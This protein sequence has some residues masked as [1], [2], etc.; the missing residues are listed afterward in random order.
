MTKIPRPEGL[1]P[2]ITEKKNLL[3]ALNA[4]SATIRADIATTN[5]RMLETPNPGTSAANR[6]RAKLGQALLPDAEPDL[7]R[8]KKQ[9]ID[10]HDVNS[11]IA[12]LHSEIEKQKTIA[13]RMICDEL[14]PEVTRLGKNFAKAFQN[15]H[16]AHSE[17]NQ[18]LDSVED[19][20]AAVSPLGRV[21]P[22][23]LGHPREVSGGYYWGFKE[24]LEAGLIEHVP[25]SVR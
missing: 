3:S 8:I 1:N 11:A 15:L 20:G 5:A 16:A 19:T 25:S 18:F 2:V 9:R 7:E 6:I 4:E 21:W 23:S 10:L 17:Y 13:S 12:I 24:F 14:R 22:S